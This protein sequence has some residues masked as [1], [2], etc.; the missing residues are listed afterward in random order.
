[1]RKHYI[2]VVG[3]L[4]GTL[5]NNIFKWGFWPTRGRSNVTG[6]MGGKVREWL[7]LDEG[8]FCQVLFD[9]FTSFVLSKILF[10]ILGRTLYYGGQF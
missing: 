7:T 5:G 1:M 9:F 6:E 10:I 8:M 2:N 3:W 4:Q